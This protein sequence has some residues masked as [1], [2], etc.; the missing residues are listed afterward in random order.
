[1]SNPI[2]RAIDTNL[3]SMKVTDRDVTRIME[4]IRQDGQP[5]VRRLKLRY[6]VVLAILLALLT[7]GGTAAVLLSPKEIISEEVLPL[8]QEGENGLWLTEEQVNKVL[9]LARANGIDVT[10][11]VHSRLEESLRKY[12]G[13]WTESLI[14][15]LMYARYGAYS[16]WPKEEDQWVEDTIAALYQAYAEGRERGPQEGELNRDEAIQR[17]KDLVWQLRDA[18][19]DDASKY[20]VEATFLDGLSYTAYPGYFWRVEFLP[21]T[22]EGAQIEVELSADGRQ[23]YDYQYF[24]GAAEADYV[25]EVGSAFQRIYGPQERWSQETLREYVACL[26]KAEA[27]GAIM[28]DLET[29]MMRTEYPDIAPEAISASRA[30]SIALEALGLTLGNDVSVLHT[31]YLGESPNP[32]WKVTIRAKRNVEGYDSDWMYLVEVD[33]ITGEIRVI[34]EAAAMFRLLYMYVPHSV[35]QTVVPDIPEDAYPVVSEGKARMSALA[36]IQARYGETRDL[37]DPELF[38]VTLKEDLGFQWI[39]NSQWIVTFDAKAVGEVGYWAYVNGFGEVVDL[40]VDNGAISQGHTLDSIRFEHEM[41][42]GII[43]RMGED[44]FDAF[45]DDVRQRADMNDPVAKLLSETTYPKIGYGEWGRMAEAVEIF[46]S[47]ELGIRRTWLDDEELTFDGTTVIST[48]GSEEAGFSRV[49]KFAIRSGK[50]N[51]LAEVADRDGE[52]SMLSVVPMENPF[53]PWYASLLLQSEMEA[54]GIAPEPYIPRGHNALV[55]DEGVVRGL[56]L[57]HIYSRFC[58]LYGDDYL[59]WSQLQLQSFQRAVAESSS[60]AVDIGVA[61]MRDTSYP[62][63]P[64]NAISREEAA[65]AGAKAMGLTGYEVEGAVLIADAPNAVWKVCYHT[66]ADWRYAEVDCVTGEVKTVAERSES[67]IWCQDLVLE[68]VLREHEETFQ[69]MSNG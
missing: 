6:A 48:K 1:M 65:E 46:A 38:D 39:S 56:P 21:K 40:G 28:H 30:N 18:E 54:A 26:K 53:D 43:A 35:Y 60:L 45:M 3:A 51:F 14:Y 10:E 24:A 55:I 2:S 50:G 63:I 27:N 66:G 57:R 52:L 11:N 17:A 59:A 64:G 16:E 23:M 58:R 69:N 44:S 5:R 25:W 67:N 15:D 34:D 8:S 33:S 7:A 37:N 12:G 13:Y 20:R 29:N 32:I 62:A 68:R 22:V 9:A 49:W 19:L 41:I 4:R 61:C 36:A 31:A 42:A 47:N